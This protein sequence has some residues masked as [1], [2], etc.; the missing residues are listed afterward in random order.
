MILFGLDILLECFMT[1]FKG[2]EMRL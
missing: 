2:N 1:L